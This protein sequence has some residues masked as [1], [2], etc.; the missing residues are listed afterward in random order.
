M[1]RIFFVD[2][3]DDSAV[4]VVSLPCPP[5]EG[6]EVFVAGRQWRV[7]LVVWH[8]EEDAPHTPFAAP[9]P[10]HRVNVGLIRVQP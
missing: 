4:G 8:I 10:L 6:E 5:R 2:C 9:V 1:I 7:V 3:A